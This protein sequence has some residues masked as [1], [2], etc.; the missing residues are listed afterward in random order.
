MELL[1]EFDVKMLASTV[2]LIGFVGLLVRLYKG[3]VAEPKRLRSLL[4]KQG[5]TGPPQA[6]LLGSISEMK[7]ARGSGGIAKG[8]SSE[9]PTSHNLAAAI[10]PF[11]E[12]CRKQFGIVLEI[13]Y[14]S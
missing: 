3:L 11:F 13:L 2:A 7:K 5:I 9:P 10:F 4:A 8:P 12:K 14:R 1:H 6:L